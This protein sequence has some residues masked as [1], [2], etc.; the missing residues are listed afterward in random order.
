MAD[1][2]A[3][4]PA[5]LSREQEEEAFYHEAALNASWTGSRLAVAIVL[6]GLGGFLFAF[7]YLRS[8]NGYGEWYPSTLTPP[9]AWQGALIMGLVVVSAIVQMVGLQM[10]KGGKKGAWVGAAVVALVLGLAAA[11]FQ[12]YQ[13]T[14]LPF[15]PGAAGFA[16][17]FVG[18][19][20][21]LVA[22]ILATMIWLEILIMRAR[23]FPDISFVEQPPTFDEA[24]DVQRFQANLSS[25]TLF[26]NFLAIA[27][28]VFWVLF[29]LV[30]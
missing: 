26:W 6:S 22:L 24:A 21:V 13:L 27:A 10:I 15:Q 11:A 20:P 25:F 23:Q 3:T 19:Q 5:G 7:F 17:V 29:Y 30:H 28:I 4:G 16:S 12:I 1:M 8:I 9:K 18:S 2:A 14:S